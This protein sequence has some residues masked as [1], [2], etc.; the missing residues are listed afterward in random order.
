MINKIAFIVKMSEVKQITLTG[1]AAQDMP[2]G[3]KKEKRSRS[4]KS[5]S[6]P[7]IITK[8]KNTTN[9]LLPTTLR[10][11]GGQSVQGVSS[12][13]SYASQPSS[14]DPKTWLK[15]PEQ[16]PIPPVIK[17]DLTPTTYG[18]NP[19]STTQTGGTVKHIKVELKKK[20]S[21]KKVHL[22]PKKSDTPKTLPHKKSQTK[23][24]RKV[25]L[26]VSSLHKRLKRAK[27]MTKKAKEMPIDKLREQLI[28]KKLI[29][30]T[31]KAPE[32]VLRQIAADAQ[33]VA[34]KAL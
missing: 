1:S 30:P 11:V 12:T 28:Q 22:Q 10:T 7:T 21:T 14:P 31:S 3:L 19:S 6:D 4:K 18:S 33:I 17:P 13:Q 26:G 16:A 32:S 8:D 5:Q 29:K 9:Q 27:K 23:K 20:T 2:G 25:T 24:L 15:Y 34:G